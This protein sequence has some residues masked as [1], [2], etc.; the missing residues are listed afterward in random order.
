VQLELNFTDFY[1]K[2]TQ[3]LLELYL[4]LKAEY[5]RSN[6]AE[7]YELLTDLNKALEQAD[8]TEIQRTC[9]RLYY[10]EGLSQQEIAHLRGVDRST[11]N[12]SLKAALKRLA[13]VFK[14]WEYWTE[15][16]ISLC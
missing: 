11:V 4:S 9:I 1:E 10:V 6:S 14:R 16:E 15:G 2:K 7:L 12:R 3:L 13:A 5:E 8:F